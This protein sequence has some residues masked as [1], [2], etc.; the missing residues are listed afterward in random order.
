MKWI[1]YAVVAREAARKAGSMLK[2][3]MGKAREIVFKGAVD[4]V[5]NFDKRSQEIICEYLSSRFPDHD[6]LAEEGLHLDRGSDFCWIID[7]IDGTTNYAHNFPVFCVSIALENKGEIVVG[8]IYDPLRE[9]MFYATKEGGAFLNGE[10]IS[11]SCV[12]ELQKS[13][14]ATGFPYDVWESQINNLDHFT[15]FITRVQAI[16][17]CGSAAIDL[18]YIACGRF[19]GFWELKLNP[20]DIAAGVLIVTEAGGSM[21]DFQGKKFSIYGDESLASNGLIHEQMIKVLQ[22]AEK[23]KE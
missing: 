12:A 7:P 3:N 18:C 10:K 1:E 13:L 9:E 17:R 2:E 20:W 6:L 4:I 22:L 19:D 21:S 5:T 11:V 8:V 16:R 14:L 15:N 23:K